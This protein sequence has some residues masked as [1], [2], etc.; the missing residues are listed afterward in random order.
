M[1]ILLYFF[2]AAAFALTAVLFYERAKWCLHMMQ[3]DGYLNGR[4]LRWLFQQPAERL[5]GGR[6]QLM[7][8]STVAVTFLLFF[9]FVH[10]GS[11]LTEQ[12]PM[13]FFSVATA[14]I[15]VLRPTPE[16][17]KKPFVLTGRA[18]RLLGTTPI[19]GLVTLCA[20]YL[21][22]HIFRLRLGNTATLVTLSILIFAFFLAS[23]AAALTL[24]A[25][26]ILIPVQSAINRSYVNKAKANLRAVNPTVVGLTGSFGK[27][28]TKYFLEA[29]IRDSV[30]TLMTP[31]SFNSF[32][33]II[34]VLNENLRPGVQVFIAEMGAY[35]PG[36]IKELAD[37]VH[38]TIGILTAIGPS[39]L[40]RFGT[41]D[42]VERT[43]Y[44]LIQSLPPTGLG[45][46]NM[47]D[48]RCRRLSFTTPQPHVGYGLDNTLEDLDVWATDIRMTPQGMTFS[49]HTKAHGSTDVRTPVL[50][51][52]NVSNIL[53]C[54]CVAL[55]L[56]VPLD[57]LR[58]RMN[59]LESAP[60]RLQ[61]IK[62]TG[63]VT[64]IDDSYNS[65][66]IGAAAALEVLSQFQSGK[67][68]LITPGMVELGS[69]QESENEKFGELAATSADFVFLI[70]GAS[71]E[72]IH[73]G[74]RNKGFPEASIRDCNELTEATNELPKI[75]S[76][77]DVVLFANDLPDLYKAKS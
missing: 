6:S 74:L 62:G 72:A 43:K 57:T 37:L 44:E 66:P 1:T 54:V 25:N 10:S 35:R 29:L 76:A 59:S 50:G 61:L 11:S 12:L 73:R 16:P 65:N 22:L 32:L 17:A 30:P 42:A 26:I 52:H 55:H 68:I 70:A 23:L 63:G 19:V 7:L 28:S 47:D 34:R 67:R 31:Q 77:G 14:L 3:L 60:H 75:V 8:S 2:T 45:V 24:A 51:K 48:P 9:V 36:D 58:R 40:E 71:S 56:G 41:V 13:L 38:P 39:H 20:I 4:F 27:T 69:K 33:G 53:A 15:L 64:V 5:M 21:V 49:I 18:R 46:F